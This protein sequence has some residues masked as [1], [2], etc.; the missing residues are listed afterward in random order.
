M[1]Y[2]S[3]L[4]RVIA[5]LGGCLAAPAALAQDASVATTVVAPVPAPPATALPPL[6]DGARWELSF[7]PYTYHWSNDPDRKNVWLVALSRLQA[8]GTIWGF[9]A[10]TN[11]FGQPSAYG[12]Y[13]HIWEGLFGQPKFY[14]KLT[15]GIL[16]G[17]KGKYEDK[18]PFNS[19]GW[20]PAIIPSVGWRLTAND[21]LE[22]AALGSAG[23][24]F[25]YNRR[26]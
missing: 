3:R 7:S 16:Y 13:G 11:S 4:V 17:Y 24:T 21:A 12:Y 19:N 9:A 5:L 14:A 10:F 20:S 26:F 18:V 23:L 1:Q 22:V 6:T 25:I 2:K 15:A 8:D